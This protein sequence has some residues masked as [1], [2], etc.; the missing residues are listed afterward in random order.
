MR[1]D[2]GEVADGSMDQTRDERPKEGRVGPLGVMG[3]TVRGEWPKEPN[4]EDERRGAGI[5]GGSE[6][7]GGSERRGRSECTAPVLLMSPHMTRSP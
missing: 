7:K 3:Q 2:D 5:G 6:R 4:C 1:K